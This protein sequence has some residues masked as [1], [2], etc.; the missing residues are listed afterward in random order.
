MNET[1]NLVIAFLLVMI[2]LF[3]WQWLTP[4]RPM[5]Q[6]VNPTPE[7]TQNIPTE[8]K[9]TPK[10]TTQLISSEEL[11]QTET[12]VTLEN[13]HFKITFSNFGGS[14]KSVYLKKYK[15]ELIPSNSYVL[16]TVLNQETN[17]PALWQI[18]YHDDS[19]VVFTNKVVKT[20]RLQD[21]YMLSMQINAET[22]L[23]ENL[24]IDYQNG[25]AFSEANHKDELRHYGVFYRNY[26]KTE[27]KSAVKLKPIALDT[28]HWIAVKSK[29]FTSIL[30]QQ[31]NFGRVQL[32]PLN[33]GRVGYQYKT[34]INQSAQFLIY[35]G[36]L[37]YDILRSHKLGWEAVVDL[38]WTRIFSVAILK[39]LMFLYAIFKNYGIAIIIFS[40]IMKAIFFPLSR[41]STR[42]MQQMQLLQPKI[43]ELKK[44]YKDNPQALNQ[45]TMQL[46]KLYKINPF[47]GCLPLLFQLPIFWA[48][49]AVLQKTIE[50][51]QANFGLWIHDLSLKDPY[52]ILPILMGVSF[53][54]QN[55]LTSADK[56]NMA[57]LIFMPIFLTVI[58]LNFPAGLQLYWLFFNLLSIVESIISRGG[59]KW[60]KQ[61]IQT[62]TEKT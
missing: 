16:G 28:I 41:M 15:A 50:L 48:L 42:Q 17:L 36:P 58:F 54:A 31:H 52:Y 26:N 49:Y 45:E 40:I 22:S 29:Y 25:L 21:N 62:V 11:K 30:A 12:E 33:D 51:R 56:R 59:L 34:P 57:L 38:G 13:K 37:H 2:V 55:F 9:E 35:F 24:V 44:K 10:P 39:I 46:Y 27:K 14:I 3:V 19:T 53:L 1:K 7:I 23:N 18:S 43:E 6:T 60:K 61:K 5:P 8:I 4:R 47:S 20:Y 32:T